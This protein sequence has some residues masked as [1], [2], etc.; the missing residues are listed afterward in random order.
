MLTWVE[1]LIKDY[2]AGVRQLEAYRK[3]LD[4][5]PIREEVIDQTEYETVSGMISDMNLALEWLRKGRRP[6]SRRGAEQ[7]GVYQRTELAKC[8][9]GLVP[10]VAALTNDEKKKIVDILLCLSTRERQ[11]YLF[12]MAHG[13][14]YAEIADRLRVSRTS[15][16]KFVERAKSKVQQGI[17]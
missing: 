6:G 3:K 9:P 14:T 17:S 10:D 16:Q 8:F 4:R 5:D 2:N 7:H 1:E 15:V 12:H 11:C 13:L